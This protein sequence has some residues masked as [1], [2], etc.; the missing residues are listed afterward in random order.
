M[1]SRAV[2]SMI[3]TPPYTPV[4]MPSTVHV[5]LPQ[6]LQPRTPQSA[7]LLSP[8]L[9]PHR[10]RNHNGNAHARLRPTPL[11]PLHDLHPPISES[12]S[13]SSDS[14]YCSE[15]YCRCGLLLG[16]RAPLPQA[17]RTQRVA[18]CKGRVYWWRYRKS[19]VQ[20]SLLRE[21]RTYVSLF[22]SPFNT[23]PKP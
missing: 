23:S 21:D 14:R 4:Y 13:P 20:G 8:R 16:R 22:P 2:P 9:P 12:R 6:T 15:M 3:E 1:T 7:S 10:S 19:G 11:P 17:F 5:H 18:R